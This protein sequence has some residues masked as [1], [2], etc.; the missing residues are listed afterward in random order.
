MSDRKSVA[1]II[2]TGSHY[3]R[4]VLEGMLRYKM[5]NTNWKVL[6]EERE[7]E[8][9][10]PLWLRDW[11]GDGII[12][13]LSTPEVTQIATERK[14]AFIE[15]TDRHSNDSDLVTLRSDDGAI[16]RLAAEHFL[17]RGFRRFAYCGVQGEAW[18]DR[19][20][21]AFR[22]RLNEDNFDCERLDLPWYVSNEPTEHQRRLV[23]WIRELPKPIGILGG[24][25]MRAKHVIDACAAAEISV[26]ERVA[27]IGVDNDEILC[28]FCEPPLSSI[29][30]SSEELGYRAAE[31][32]DRLMN[33]LEVKPL[34]QTIDPIDVFVRESSDT[35][36]IE[37][38]EMAKALVFIRSHACDGITVDDILAHTQ[39]SRS[40]LERR[41]RKLLGRSPQQEIRKAQLKRV[42]KL[43]AETDLVIEAIGI[44]CGFDRPEYLHVLFKR[45]FQMTPGEY[46][47]IARR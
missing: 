4:Q 1:L 21:V 41:T 33:H 25:D 31:A 19:R 44:K 28:K 14:L 12:C 36:A 32:L 35:I 23:H 39:F 47:K 46:R 13:R 40:S 3:G 29:L 8:A 11:R 37:D 2:E 17:E 16:G 9:S 6:L 30:P 18:S 27:V 22:D 5:E 10:P 42:K 26:P 24:N 38:P 20:A 34:L 7:L 45:E 15:L 43:L